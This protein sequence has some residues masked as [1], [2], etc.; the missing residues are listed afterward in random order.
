MHIFL[1]S[2]FVK[3][4]INSESSS[5]FHYVDVESFYSAAVHHVV[6]NIYNYAYASHPAHPPLMIKY[7]NVDAQLY[8]IRLCLLENLQVSILLKNKII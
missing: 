7:E 5:F 1:S 3:L 6:Y 8:A 2:Y 4:N